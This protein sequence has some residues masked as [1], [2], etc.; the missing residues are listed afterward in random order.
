MGMNWSVLLFSSSSYK[1]MKKWNKI[2]NFNFFLKFTFSVYSTQ[3]GAWSPTWSLFRGFDA[4]NH[5]NT[6]LLY[7][8]TVDLTFELFSTLNYVAND[9]GSET[10]NTRRR[11][12]TEIFRVLTLT[13][14]DTFYYLRQE[15][16][17]RIIVFFSVSL[18]KSLKTKFS[19]Q[20]SQ[21]SKVSVFK[22]NW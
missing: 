9:L 3:T 22:G 10:W 7:L 20:R 14:F 11:F 1:N 16:Q 8:L 2:R 18:L 13:G 15:S 19:I 21:Y 12:D 5:S 17:S 4:R 6:R